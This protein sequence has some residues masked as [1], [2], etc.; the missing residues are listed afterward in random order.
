FDAIVSV[1]VIEHLYDPRRFM[2]RA[3]E[4]LK[5]GGL[6]VLTT[7]Y[8]GYLKNIALALT[9][10]IDRALTPL[11]DGGHIKHW[12]YKTLRALGEE[13]PFE[14]VAF[15]GAGRPI[16]YLWNGMIMVFRK[17]DSERG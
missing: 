13:L 14:F 6:L 16:P 3:Y 2:R 11:W 7:P 12:S 17:G 8:W 1:E 10:R 5:P 4:A 15:R 9:N